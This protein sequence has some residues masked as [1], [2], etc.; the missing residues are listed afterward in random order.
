MA[1]YSITKNEPWKYTIYE[2]LLDSWELDTEFTKRIS[3]IT[4]A[5]VVG[6]LRG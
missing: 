6:E 3:H 4:S 1:S 5:P 2:R